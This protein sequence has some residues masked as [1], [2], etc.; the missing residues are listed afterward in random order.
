MTPDEMALSLQL[1]M[2]TNGLTALMVTFLS[3]KVVRVLRQLE[4][5]TGSVGGEETSA[6]SPS[7]LRLMEKQDPVPKET[8]SEAYVCLYNAMKASR[9]MDVLRAVSWEVKDV[10]RHAFQEVLEHLHPNLHGY[11][12]ELYEQRAFIEGSTAG[13][14]VNRYSAL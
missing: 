4:Q 14:R 3:R 13:S 2:V 10:P 5:A 12:W 8:A 11:A 9:N 1:L 7:A 6:A